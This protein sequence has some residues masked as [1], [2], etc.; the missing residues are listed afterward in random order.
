MHARSRYFQRFIYIASLSGLIAILCCLSNGCGG[1]SPAAFPGPAM[2]GNFSI[3]A[4]SSGT[5][6]VNTFI[7]GIQTDSTGH[8]RGIVHVQGSLLV[9]FGFFID[10]P[11][12]GTIDLA[13]H[14]NATITGSG[15]QTITLNATVSPD[16]ALLSNG[17][18]S[19][20]GTGC[21]AG[22]QGS[23]TGFQVQAFTGTYTGT[24]NP[25]PSTNIT[26]ALPLV[27]S[28]AADSHG[29]F[30]VSASTVTV[31]GG[32]ACGFSSATLVPGSSVAS[33]DDLEVILLGSDNLSVMIFI[34]TATDGNTSVVH[35]L[36]LI[37][38][39]PCSGQNGLVNLSRP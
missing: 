9:C 19:G 30:P 17:S 16:G 6:G 37:D 4:T 21:V 26:L 25:S 15:N 11:L 33:G 23:L 28:P 1:S 29:E 39:G 14:L 10:M 35:G 12:I 38:T 2:N 22:D 36:V 32:A 8:V 5:L 13:G 24:F 31:T 7:G 27:Q 18:Y 3:S 20:N 34:G